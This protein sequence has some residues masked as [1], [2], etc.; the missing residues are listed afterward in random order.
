MA[1]YLGLDDAQQGDLG[2]HPVGERDGGVI[3]I[4]GEGIFRRTDPGGRLAPRVWAPPPVLAAMSVAR[5]DGATVTSA[6]VAA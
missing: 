4:E 6:E 3:A 1:V 5:R 2:G